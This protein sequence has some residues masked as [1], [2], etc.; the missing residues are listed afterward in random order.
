MAVL[1]GERVVVEQ[2]AALRGLQQDRG[3]GRVRVDAGGAG[4]V[5][6][7]GFARDGDA[8]GVEGGAGGEVGAGEVG[9]G[10]EGEEGL[11]VGDDVEG[12]GGVEEAVVGADEEDAVVE[13]R[14]CGFG[15]FV[16]CQLFCVCVC[17]CGYQSISPRSPFSLFARLF[18]HHPVFGGGE[19]SLGGG[20]R[21][22]KK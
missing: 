7:A 4:G 9:V 11:D 22:G 2:L 3:R 13:G 5:A 20:L 17:V 10:E 8:V 1:D 12:G 21:G 14:V 19:R 6:A 18:F 15:G 16:S